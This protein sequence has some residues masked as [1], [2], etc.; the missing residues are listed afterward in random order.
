MKHLEFTISGNTINTTAKIL[1]VSPVSS[2]IGCIDINGTVGTTE[3]SYSVAVKNRNSRAGVPQLGLGCFTTE[4]LAIDAF[5]EY[6]YRN[7]EDI[8]IDMDLL[9]TACQRLQLTGFDADMTALEMMV[10]YAKNFISEVESATHTRILKLDIG[11]FDWML[12][13]MRDGRTTHEATIALMNMVR[14]CTDFI[15]LSHKTSQLVPRILLKVTAPHLAEMNNFFSATFSFVNNNG[16]ATQASSNFISHDGIN[17]HAVAKLGETKTQSERI[18]GRIYAIVDYSAIVELTTLPVQEAF[19]P[20]GVPMVPEKQPKI[21]YDETLRT[22]CITIINRDK[23]KESAFIIVET[24]NSLKT[25][26]KL[27][28][29]P[30]GAGPTVT[31][32]T[33]L[34]LAKA[35]YEDMQRPKFTIKALKTMV[36]SLTFTK[37][38]DKKWLS[39]RCLGFTVGVRSMT[40]T[41]SLKSPITWL[42]Y[43]SNQGLSEEAIATLN[44][45][46]DI[47]TFINQ[48]QPELDECESRYVILNT[49]A[50]LFYK[51]TTDLN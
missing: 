23:P 21:V 15:Q 1:N 20:Q 38:M 26:A 18:K 19:N 14:G 32:H 27:I 2:F 16:A 44:L 33:N 9:K 46:E 29:I 6:I 51:Q 25:W 31:V 47:C 37:S 36:A 41:A 7:S 34:E 8:P 11:S 10:D 48:T 13:V 3:V 4:A 39:S 12:A 42:E 43:L 22:N 28:V 5:K 49:Y 35:F 30:E 40:P 50:E 45:L 17:W 24:D